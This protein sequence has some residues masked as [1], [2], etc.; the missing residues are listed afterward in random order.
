MTPLRRLARAFGYD[1]VPLKKV[2]SAGAQIVRILEQERV[3]CVLD[4]GANVGQ[5]AKRLRRDG[6][7]GRILSF[8]PVAAV[9]A[10]LVAAARPDARW[11]VAPRMA[12]GA[13]DG[14]AVIEVSAES[15]MSSLRPQSD[16][17]Q[18]V[19]PSS[20]I[21]GR[22]PVTLRRLDGV[23]DVELGL[24]DRAFLKI[25]TQGSEADVLA[26]ATGLLPRLVGIQLELSFRPL[27]DGEPD[28]R[29]MIWALGEAGF[30]P[31]LFLP[32]YFERKTARQL[33]FDGVFVR[34]GH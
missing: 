15:D 28:Y 11:R 19:S 2:R 18:R 4:V 17:L 1:L 6:Y 14:E 29:A 5:Y 16:L 20:E 34:T 7:T 24:G 9:H 31:A 23:A 21:I 25:D 30:E 12:L 33:Q 27:Y 3:S 8:E 26:G 22:E 32:G 13:A 10:E